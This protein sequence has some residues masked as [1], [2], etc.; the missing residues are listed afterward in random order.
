[1]NSEHLNLFV[2]LGHFRYKSNSLEQTINTNGTSDF[3]MVNN[4]GPVLFDAFKYAQMILPTFVG[5]VKFLYLDRCLLLLP[6]VG[7]KEEAVAASG[8]SNR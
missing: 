1:M 8:I 7:G 2:E 5:A 4:C 3:R 6:V